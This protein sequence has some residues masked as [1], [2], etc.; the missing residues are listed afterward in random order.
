MF[1]RNLAFFIKTCNEN[2]IN[3]V[4]GAVTAMRERLEEQDPKSLL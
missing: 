2:G 1:H 4:V 3:F